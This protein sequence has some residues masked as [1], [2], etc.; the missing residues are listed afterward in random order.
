MSFGKKSELQQGTPMNVI[1][2]G[3]SNT[4][5]YDPRSYFG[6]RYDKVWTML[7]AEKTGWNVI[8]QGQNGREIPTNPISF[9]YDTDFL[10]IMLGTNDLLQGNSEELVAARM[11]RFLNGL[12]LETN[13]ILL[14]APPP[15]QLGE[16]VPTQT[17]ID[18]SMHLSKHYQSIARK[19]DVRFVD[20][21]AWKI[22]LTFDGVHFTE[23]GHRQFAEGLWKEMAL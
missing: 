5:G 16:W 14:I 9:P 22:S 19:L 1:C 20:A 23:D 3:D 2:Y 13:K 6:G 11:E 18:A 4:W 12:S 10:I 7:L 15:M 17:L 21:N 8:N